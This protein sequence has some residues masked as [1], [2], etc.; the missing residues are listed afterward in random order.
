MIQ[1]ANSDDP[2]KLRFAK[3][4]MRRAE[5]TAQDIH[6]VHSPDSPL[7]PRGTPIR[8]HRHNP[9]LRRRPARNPHRT[10]PRRRACDVGSQNDH[11]WLCNACKDQS[12]QIGFLRPPGASAIIAAGRSPY[13]TLRRAAAKCNCAPRFC[14]NCIH[15]P[16]RTYIRELLPSGYDRPS[17]ESGA[18]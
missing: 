3:A 11:L 18:Q 5:G 13:R 6:A 7:T 1:I 10:P 2:A 15:S 4:G 12:S 9:P 8:R 16:K 17:K 14:G